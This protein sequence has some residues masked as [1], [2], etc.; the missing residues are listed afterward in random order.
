[1]EGS[2]PGAAPAAVYLSHRIIRPDQSG[3]GKVLGQALFNSKRLY[4]AIITMADAQDD[5]VVVPVQQIPAEREGKSPEEI[6]RQMAFIKTRIAAVQNNELIRDSEAMD[7]LREL[8]SDQ[9]IITYGLNFKQNGVLN[10]RAELANNFMHDVFQQLSV[11]PSA[12]DPG[13]MAIPD[14]IITTSDF[15][16]EEYG[17]DFVA[18]YMQRIGVDPS[19]SALPTMHF[20][21]STTMCPWLTA[22]AEGNFIPQLI[23]AFRTAVATV[24]P[25][26]R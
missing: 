5:F 15:D 14:M 25:N 17:D 19:G 1:M 13:K 2:K 11:R 4:S 3:Y 12:S 6:R 23:E 8:G 7:L 26:Y 21:S 20:I 22:T 18:T 10:S 24:L 16:P 9:I